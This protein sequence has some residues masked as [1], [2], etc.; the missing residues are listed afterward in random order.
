MQFGFQA[1][2]STEA[3][4]CFF[5]ETIKQKMDKAGIVGA[6]IFIVKRRLILSTTKVS[7]LASF[8]LSSKKLN[9]MKLYL[10]GRIQCVRVGSETS[11]VLRIEMSVPQGSILGPHLTRTVVVKS[12]QTL[13]EHVYHNFLEFQWFPC[14]YQNNKQLFNSVQQWQTWLSCTL[15][16]RLSKLT[17][18]ESIRSIKCIFWVQWKWSFYWYMYD[19][20]ESFPVRNILSSL[21]DY[22]QGST[23]DR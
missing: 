16:P 5:L 22:L 8:N 18:N 15:H 13:K 10:A 4:T 14:K 19:F 11:P 20:S 2:P 17:L 1:K 6:V 23:E 9:R 12:F 21:S 7:K 3:A